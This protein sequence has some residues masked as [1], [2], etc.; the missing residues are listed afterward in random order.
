MEEKKKDYLIIT[1][2]S[3]MFILAL[4]L[5]MI[6][7]ERKPIIYKE[8]SIEEVEYESYL[9]SLIK[10]GYVEEDE[11]TF[12]N[13]G[14]KISVTVTVYNPVSAQC[15]DTPL[16]TADN[17]KINTKKLNKGEI[18]WI[19]VSRD[20][21]K[22]GISYGDKVRIKSKTDPTINGIYEVHDTMHKRWRNRIDLLSP[23]NKTLGK[24]ENV[25]LELLA[26]D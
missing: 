15:D 19:A 2:M 18:K 3:W 11:V 10:N 17:S 24:W 13:D 23:E 9:D 5:P 4:L 14:D 6:F 25:E 22:R 8:R 1:V 7:G 26:R 12:I 20:L 21:L 16:I